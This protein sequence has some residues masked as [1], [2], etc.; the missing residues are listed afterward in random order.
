MIQSKARRNYA[1]S[2]KT[3]NYEDQ[4]I[5]YGIRA[6]ETSLLGRVLTKKTVN[7][8]AIEVAF[9]NIWDKPAGFKVEEVELKLFQF[10]FQNKEDI[11][12]ILN[13]AD[14]IGSKVT[15]SLVIHLIARPDD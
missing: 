4:D 12:R 6:C 10:V 8:Y 13:R 5:A 2:N 3:L 7:R 9:A 1:K 11:L 15:G 14:R